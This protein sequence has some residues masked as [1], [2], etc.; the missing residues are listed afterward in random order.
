MNRK[1]QSRRLRIDEENERHVREIA[2]TLGGAGRKTS[3]V[4][5]SWRQMA[6]A[7]DRLLR[8]GLAATRGGEP[9]AA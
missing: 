8:E 6:E 5:P 9:N 1:D 4:L 7:A 3:R 2:A